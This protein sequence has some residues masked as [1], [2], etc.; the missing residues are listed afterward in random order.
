MPAKPA[1]FHGY[2][3][4]Q[5]RMKESEFEQMLTEIAHTANELCA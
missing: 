5:E 3:M 1:F 2:P 4:P